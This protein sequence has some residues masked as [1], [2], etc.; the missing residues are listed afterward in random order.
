MSIGEIALHLNRA[1][2]TVSAQK[3]RAMKKLCIERDADLFQ[4]AYE[5]D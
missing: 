3:V 5:T 1:K 2:Q 4:Y